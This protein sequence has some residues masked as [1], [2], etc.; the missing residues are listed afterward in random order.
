MLSLWKLW[1]HPARVFRKRHRPSPD[2]QQPGEY[3][4]G[5]AV[6]QHELNVPQCSNSVQ[7]DINTCHLS[8]ESDAQ[9]HTVHSPL[10]SNYV[11][12]Q[13]HSVK[14][15][16]LVDSGAAISCINSQLLAKNNVFKNFHV[17]ESDRQYIVSATGECTCIEGMIYVKGII[18]K[19]HNS[20][21]FKNGL[22][23]V[24]IFPKLEING[25]RKCPKCLMLKY[26][27]RHIK[28]KK[29]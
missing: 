19:T 23:K 22:L 2:K 3:R 17:Q 12:L 11:Q 18:N 14:F 24:H 7:G 20:L 4:V 8:T 16:A 28:K 5:P 1:P 13:I 27:L 21:S 10:L 6:E 26:K 29:K 25:R 9:V 15:F